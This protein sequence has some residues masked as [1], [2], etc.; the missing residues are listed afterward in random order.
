VPPACPDCCVLSIEGVYTAKGYRMDFVLDG[1]KETPI[2]S[3]LYDATPLSIIAND[4]SIMQ[5]ASRIVHKRKFYG[6][7]AP[8]GGAAAKVLKKK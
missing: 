4:G 5:Q 1:G 3:C 6:A 2:F 8:E 7:T